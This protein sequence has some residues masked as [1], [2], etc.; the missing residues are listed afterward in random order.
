MIES[1]AAVSARFLILFIQSP[2]SSI[3]RHAVVGRRELGHASGAVSYSA[4]LGV[5]SN[6]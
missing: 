3:V 6:F 2:R 4:F 1:D 5:G